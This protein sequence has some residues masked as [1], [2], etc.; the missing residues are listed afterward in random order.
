MIVRAFPDK[1]GGVSIP[2]LRK[3]RRNLL[4][5]QASYPVPP[6]RE[7]LI[8]RG[9]AARILAIPFAELTRKEE[10]WQLTVHRTSGG[11]RRYVR[12]EIEDLARRLAGERDF[13]TVAQLAATRRVSQETARS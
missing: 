13:L 3:H 7:D 9:K 2:V 1:S 10:F 5:Q 12:G 6:A 4:T 11:H 8:A